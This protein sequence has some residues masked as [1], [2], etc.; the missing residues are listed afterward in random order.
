MQTKTKKQIILDNLRYSDDPEKIKMLLSIYATSRYLKVNVMTVL[1]SLLGY[2]KWDKKIIELQSLFNNTD[3]TEIEIVETFNNFLLNEEA[4]VDYNNIK[5]VKRLI[6][7]PQTMDN[8]MD[9][10]FAK[11]KSE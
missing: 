7:S 8:Y 3:V 6:S 10:L 9:E 1:F 5:S 4:L 11:L 2:A